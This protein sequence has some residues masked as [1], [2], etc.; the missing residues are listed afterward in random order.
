MHSEANAHEAPRHRRSILGVWL[1]ALLGAVPLLTSCATT[2]INQ[3]Q[4]NL[5]SR[6]E[7]WQA[8]KQLERQL[9]GK[10]KL[11]NDAATVSYV[12]Q[13]GRRIVAQTELAD[14]PW[15]FHV[16]A[17]PAINAFDIPGGH[18]YVNTGLI[19]KAGDTSELAGVMAHEIGHGVARHATE[20]MSRMYGIDLGAGLVLG[21]NASAVE[22][23]AAQIA[24]TGVAAKFSRADEREADKLGVEYMYRAGYDPRGMSRIFQKLL[25][26][27]KRRP[28]SVEQFFSTHPLEED[29]ITQVSR[30]ISNL[31]QR[32]STMLADDGRLSAIQQRVR[33]YNG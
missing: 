28:S 3:G 9:A 6:D 33:R 18:V 12:T 7:E 32:R 5:I 13:I 25:N 29:R 1:A 10:L 2:G 17:D 31:P 15:T 30:Q 8:G 20:Q 23:I 27:R 11:V 21:R 24:E 22:Q 14:A 19:L 26:E 4:F 16:V